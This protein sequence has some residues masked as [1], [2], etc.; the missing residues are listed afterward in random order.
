[1]PTTWRTKRCC[2]WLV[3]GLTVF[4]PACGW[5][6]QFTV[7]GYTTR[8]NYDSTIRTVYVP[9]FGN[10]TL[11]P[12][13]EMDL[14]R[15]VIREIES[16]TPYKVSSNRAA[17][18]TE[19]VGKIA[20]I[21]KTVINANQLNEVREAQ[22]VMNVEIVWRDLRPGRQGDVLSAQRQGGP[23]APAPFPVGP[24]MPPLPPTLVTSYGSFV[25][26]V[27]GSITSAFKENVDRA[28]VQII[29]MMEKP[30]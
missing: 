26:E 12:Q 18:D 4:L 28:A 7:L 9:I 5:D 1:M 23:G 20:L 24:D 6:G 19:L 2:C 30:W 16:K 14:T 15:A 29:S 21:T 17:A 8:P 10:Q 3:L 22:T 11:Y 27:G 13:V 25:P